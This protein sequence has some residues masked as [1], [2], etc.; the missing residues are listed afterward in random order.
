MKKLICFAFVQSVEYRIKTNSSNGSHTIESDTMDATTTTMINR[1]AYQEQIRKSVIKKYSTIW[2]DEP[3]YSYCSI[4][5]NT[6]I[7]SH[8]KDLY[9]VVERGITKIIVKRGA[10]STHIPLP[11]YMDDMSLKSRCKKF[12]ELVEDIEYVVEHDGQS[13][14]VVVS[15]ITDCK[16]SDGMFA[17]QKLMFVKGRSSM[18][19]HAFIDTFVKNKNS[20]GKISVYDV[21]DR[22]WAPCGKLGH[23]N[24]DTL[25]LKDGVLADVLADAKDFIDSA[26]DYTKFGIPY[27]RVY[28]LS[29]EPG[30]GKTS[31]SK[32]LA[33]ATGRSLYI[34]NFDAAMTDDKL[35]SAVS[36]LQG[37]KAILLLED[38]DSIFKE[39]DT[40]A[41]MTHVSFSALLNILDGANVVE[42]LI[43]IITT[44]HIE[45][46]DPALI[47]PLRVDKIIK[48]EKADA[49]QIKRLIGLYGLDLKEV[50]ISNIVRYASSQAMA[51]AGISAFLFGHRKTALTDDNI[52]S[53]FKSYV[54]KNSVDSTDKRLY[55]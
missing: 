44:N 6:F 46:L 55:V 50:T 51:P 3:E 24:P 11:L 20:A 40:N 38:I 41:N 34:L 12:Y 25:I 16:P 17:V 1:Q 4:I 23:R 9:S 26:K 33:S 52:L 13:Y 48:F 28:M 45:L 53:T 32:I 15:N 35:F 5:K 30:T 19:V 43:T 22:F 21:Q 8:N 29:G 18:S 37:K 7:A 36:H 14:K 42:G 31:L 39:R 54:E 10:D 49:D 2:P 47:R 27:K